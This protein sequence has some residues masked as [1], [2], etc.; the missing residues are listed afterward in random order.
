MLASDEPPDLTPVWVGPTECNS[1]REE[2]T[3]TAGQIWAGLVGM[4]KLAQAHHTLG[5]AV[6]I[7]RESLSCYQNGAYMA[8]ILMCRCATEA[9]VYLA[10]SRKPSPPPGRI[11]VD[12]QHINAH[13]GLIRNQAKA[14]GL[15]TENDSTTLDEIRQRGHY[16]AH[17]GQRYDERTQSDMATITR[18]GV[19]ADGKQAEDNLQKTATVLGHVIQRFLMKP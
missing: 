4:T 18:L 17:Y 11:E 12:F 5:N 7:F 19:W 2:R 9:V 6:D 10:V 1:A 15:L 3:R 13:W 8:C 16:V 14:S